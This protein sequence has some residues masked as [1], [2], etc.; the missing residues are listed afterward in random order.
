MR[1][2]RIRL[3]LTAVILMVAGFTLPSVGPAAATFP[4]ANG[5]IAFGDF[6]T[7]QI[8]A[9]NPDGTGFVQLTHVGDGEFAGTPRWSPDGKHIAFASNMS[10]P[11]RL[12]VMDANGSSLSMLAI[13]KRG[14]NVFTPTYTPNGRRLLFSRCRHE[15]CAL[16]SVRTDGTNRQALTPFRLEVVDLHPSVSPNGRRIAFQRFGAKGI[17]S[18]VYVMRAD[19]SGAHALT[20]PALE[21]SFPDWSPDGQDITFTS[22]CCRL[23]QN[24]YV[25]NANGTGI[26]P[27]T[28]ET[29]P[30]NGITSAYSPQGDQIV[31]AS[32]RRY[33]DF[34]CND[35]FVMSSTGAHETLIHTGSTGV[36]DVAWGSA[37]LI[38]A[39]S[40]PAS[41]LP[42]ESPA[43]TRA[44]RA[45]VCKELPVQMSGPRCG[46]FG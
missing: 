31:F 23:G 42:S 26:E 8:Y 2:A 17:I 20:P 29:F 34:C 41:G 14:V 11:W 28:G 24:I 30:N 6:N 43:R 9:V 45:A 38:S 44:R 16:F 46:G 12:W 27:L 10:G 4:G 40:G 15:G 5:R 22:N 33:D 25:M 19:G 37:P 36:Q 18:Q 35:L 3:G 7:G 21:A 32:D 39:S 13:D 1:A